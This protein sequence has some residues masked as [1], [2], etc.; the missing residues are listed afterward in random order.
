MPKKLPYTPNSRIKSMCRQLFLRSRE[1]AAVLKRDK[2][3]CQTCG[4]KK[5]V[6]KGK[7]VKVQVHHRNNITNWQEIYDT[8]RKHLLCDPA[9]ME[10]LCKG[11]HDLET[12]HAKQDIRGLS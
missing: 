12:H 1:H 4:K 8:I 9:E 2:Y 10:V 11:C 6:A 7:E 5:S 3:T